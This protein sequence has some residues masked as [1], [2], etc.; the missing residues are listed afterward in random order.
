MTFFNIFQFILLQL[1]LVIV[2]IYGKLHDF[3]SPAKMEENEIKNCHF[4]IFLDFLTDL[5]GVGH[6]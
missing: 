6:A 4:Q 2:N 5:H 3:S 1:V